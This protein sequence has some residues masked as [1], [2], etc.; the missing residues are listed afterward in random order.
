MH[1][2]SHFWS[3]SVRAHI[4]A[5]AV[6]IA[7]LPG[8]AAGADDGKRHA[9]FQQGVTAIQAE[10]WEDAL[11]IYRKLW[12][13]EQTYDVALSLGQVELNLKAYRPAAEH[14]AFGLAHVP[15]RE[16]AAVTDRARR[17]L[18]MA[19][20]EVGTLEIRVDRTNAE[21]VLDGKALVTTPL[22]PM[23]FVDPG[24]HT[25]E[26]TSPGSTPIVQAISLA[27]GEQK[28]L[29]L[30][31]GERGA[32]S[33]AVTDPPAPQT[34]V[35]T[36]PEAPAPPP[37]SD[38]T[39]EK[40]SGLPPRTMVLIAGGALTAGFLGLSLAE[41]L[42]AN[43]AQD[44]V[45]QRRAEVVAKFGRN[46]AEGS[47]DPDC[48]ALSEAADRRNSA[49][50]VATYALAGA[51]VSAAATIALFFLWPRQTNGEA[52]VSVLVLPHQGSASFAASFW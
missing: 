32:G 25:V 1:E 33:S 24:A 40:S 49:N 28:T 3:H 13:E 34:G 39:G 51:G 38:T 9:A 20:H 29:N 2:R 45:D 46:C 15:P 17:M 5:I 52:H 14:L 41:K 16:E 22:P 12:D 23:I 43:G 48:M 26:A 50:R 11:A 21:I 30:A 47:T 10:K 44:D 37:A 7:S 31:F 35:S 42:R 8:A 6:A 18:D 4:A 36:S 19:R 27:R